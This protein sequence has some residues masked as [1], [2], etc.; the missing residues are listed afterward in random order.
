VVGEEALE[1][2]TGPGVGVGDCVLSLSHSLCLCL[3]VCLSLSLS[4][5]HTHTHIHT[6]ICW[7]SPQDRSCPETAAWLFFFQACLISNPFQLRD[8]RS[9]VE[10]R[11]RFFLIP[12]VD[13]GGSS[14][15]PTGPA[16]KDSGQD[17]PAQTLMQTPWALQL[18]VTS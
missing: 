15:A 14:T 3:S 18:Q 8:L 12:N 9:A 5:T 2:G 6:H 7:L 13:A 10:R 1:L 16:R 4:H 17:E 11:R